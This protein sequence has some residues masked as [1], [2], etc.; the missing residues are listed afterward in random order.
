M[1][2]YQYVNF[3]RVGIHQLKFEQM[4]IG[5]VHVHQGKKSQMQITI[6]IRVNRSGNT[7]PFTLKISKNGFKICNKFAYKLNIILYCHIKFG[8]MKYF[9]YLCSHIIMHSLKH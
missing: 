7:A 4:Q 8:R 3:V 1:S 2:I 9:Q 5:E 6:A